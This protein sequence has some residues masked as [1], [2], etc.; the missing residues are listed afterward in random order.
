MIPGICSESIRNRWGTVKTSDDA[1]RL[2]QKSDDWVVNKIG[3]KLDAFSKQLKPY[4]YNNKGQCTGALKSISG[5][6]I[7]PVFLICPEA[8]ECETHSCSGHAIALSTRVRDIPHVTLIKG[9]KCYKNVNV[10]SGKCSKC[11]IFYY[12]DY[13]SFK[14]PHKTTR[15]RFYL[16][17]AKYLKIGQNIWVD[18]VFS[19]AVVNGV[20]SFHASVSAFLNSGMIAFYQSKRQI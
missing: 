20:Y 3:L 1:K 14:N 16:N 15:D 6:A 12:I 9:T 11:E 8:M 19:G 5:L 17:S 13:E 2:F 4:P 18:W 7:E 10:L